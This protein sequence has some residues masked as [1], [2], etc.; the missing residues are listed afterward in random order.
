MRIG[1]EVGLGKSIDG[2]GD[3]SASV[4][5][6]TVRP[7]DAAKLIREIRYQGMEA[8]YLLEF[9]ANRF[10]VNKAHSVWENVRANLEGVADRLRAVVAVHH[11]WS[12]LPMVEFHPSSWGDSIRPRLISEVRP[13]VRDESLDRKGR[14]RFEDFLPRC[15]PCN[16]A[17]QRAIRELAPVVGVH[18]PF[19][20]GPKTMTLNLDI[21]GNR[22][23]VVRI[24]NGAY[25]HGECLGQIHPRLAAE[26]SVR[27]IVGG[28]VPIPEDE[29][30]DFSN[31]FIAG[32]SAS[33]TPDRDTSL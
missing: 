31:E 24:A 28:M 6:R 27:G 23:P 32:L 9:Y 3:T 17:I 26:L 22:T 12:E 33:I 5:T 14:I 10:E 1:L 16:S 29:D 18:D 25:E 21:G 15:G 30:A 7:G 19:W 13:L 20:Y 11:G 2:M 4:E 8:G